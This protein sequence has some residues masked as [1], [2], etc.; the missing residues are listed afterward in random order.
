MFDNANYVVDEII[1]VIEGQGLTV[2][3]N[4]S[5]FCNIMKDLIIETEE[6]ELLNLC[7]SC[8]ILGSFEK[9]LN[10][11]CSVKDFNDMLRNFIKV[12]KIGHNAD[13]KNYVYNVFSGLYHFCLTHQKPSP[14]LIDNKA[15]LTKNEE[16]S[17]NITNA[18]NL[19]RTIATITNKIKAFAGLIIAGIVIILFVILIITLKSCSSSDG[20]S[21]QGYN[22]DY[23]SNSGFYGDYTDDQDNY[24][25]NYDNNDSN[26][27]TETDDTNQH[28]SSTTQ[29]SETNDDQSTTT[30]PIYKEPTKTKITGNKITGALKNEDDIYYYTFTPSNTGMHRFDF[31][32]S[33]VNADYEFEIVTSKGS[34]WGEFYYSSREKGMSLELNAGETYTITIAYDDMPC[35]YEILIGK[36]DPEKTITGTTV[37]ASLNYEDKCNEYK[38]TAP[39]TG[40][41]RFSFDV[42]NVNADFSFRMYNSKSAEIRKIKYSAASYATNDPGTTISLKAG[43]TYT[44]WVWQDYLLCDYTINIGVPNDPTRISGTKVNGSFKYLDQENT[45]TY[46]AP[47]DGTY[48]FYL[49]ISNTAADFELRM[50]NSK[51]STIRSTNYAAAKYAKKRAEFSED[52]KAGETYTITV[53]QDYLLCDYTIEVVTP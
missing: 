26:D 14:D 10:K 36:P 6:K 37:S 21:N 4:E 8:G 22:N 44:I 5:V 7:V 20:S 30:E 51:N 43:E 17:L 41:Y 42:S 46:V 24:D 47:K 38:Y 40:V 18:A 1:P 13:E 48:T 12:Q 50:I 33:N 53:Y 27:Q 9:Y 3:D 11:K 23:S 2:I 28:S 49:D 32:I 31:D 29:N 45:Y 35:D 52:L 16:V 34:S 25:Y 19:S 15:F 39:K